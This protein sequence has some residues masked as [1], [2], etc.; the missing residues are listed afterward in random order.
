MATLVMQMNGA[1]RFTQPSDKILRDLKMKLKVNNDFGGSWW[2][3]TML[4]EK[5]FILKNMVS[6]SI[7]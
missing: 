4:A 1:M 6:S 7:I 3:N 5:G 2:L